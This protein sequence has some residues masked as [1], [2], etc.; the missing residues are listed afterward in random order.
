MLSILLLVPVL[1]LAT[2][3]RADG[4]PFLNT[5]YLIRNAETN[6]KALG[7][8][9]SPRGVQRAQCLPSVRPIVLRCLP[10]ANAVFTVW[11]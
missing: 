4:E 1:L 5:V 10:F 9:L 7:S 8:G 6:A 3:A 11:L 2:L